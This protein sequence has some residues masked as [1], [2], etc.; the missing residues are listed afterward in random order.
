MD[1]MTVT[2]AVSVFLVGLVARL[3]LPV[4][5]ALLVL[6]VPVLVI[7]GVRR[8]WARGREAR[9]RG[10]LPLRPIVPAVGGSGA[11]SGPPVPTLEQVGGYAWAADAGYAPGH[12]WIRSA[13]DGMRVGLDDLAQ[14]LLG[15]TDAVQLAAPGTVVAEGEAAGV[16][17]CGDKWGTIASPVTGTVT[18]VNEDVARDPS[19]IHREPY[20]R[21]WLFTIAPA[22]DSARV[23]HGESARA[24]LADEA[25]RLTRF[26]ERDLGLAAADGGEIVAPPPSL[27][28]AGQ[29]RALT[30]SFLV[31]APVTGDAAPPRTTAA[32]RPAEIPGPMHLGRGVLGLLAGGL[33]VLLL[34]A[35]GVGAIV[36]FAGVKGWRLLV[37][38]SEVAF[39]RRSHH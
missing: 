27:L 13:P 18:A 21:G 24:W 8:L 9:D 6:S 10:A 20:T 34:P 39:P 29:W 37:R 31:P 7:V 28:T 12:T 23:R 17:H 38:A 1:L 33:Y 35:V 11:V 30:T 4:V 19:L 15:G 16:V 2:Q 32:A 36:Y 5:A 25:A 26:L 14:R 3:L 22:R